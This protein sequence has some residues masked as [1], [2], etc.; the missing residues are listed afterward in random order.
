MNFKS[1]LFLP[2]LP[3]VFSCAQKVQ[4]SKSNSDQTRSAKFEPADGEVLIF[5]GQELDAVGGLANHSDGYY[6]FFPKPAGF[7]AYTDF[8]TGNNSFGYIHKGL[9][10]LTTT[11][12]WG[13]GPENVSLQVADPDFKNACLALGLDMSQGND[14]VTAIGGHDV[15][16]NRLGKYLKSLGNRPV[17]LRIGYEFDGVDWN[18]YKPVHYVPAFRRIHDKLQAM[19]VTNVAYTWQSKGGGATPKSLEEFYPGDEYV[20]WVAFSYFT[21]GEANHPMIQFG[22]DHHKPLLIAE[23]SP[24][25]PDEKFVSIPL[26]LTKTEDAQRAWKDWFAVFFETINKN[27]DVIKGF[28]YINS[29]WKTRP[30]WKNNGFFKN[31]DAR[32]TK[33]EY[34]K[35]QWLKETNQAKYIKAT[36]G[37]F[38]YLWKK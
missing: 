26:D 38:D 22:R 16:I 19:G 36:D 25:F 37:L 6:D 9:D 3:L 32:I 31:I 20:D 30:M 2:I 12:D 17:F 13:D 1:L 14:S 23:A 28:S 10:G 33:N 18:H 21:V 27:P 11:D 35:A 8:L 5:A 24:V 29:P 7:T 34:M 4:T 15:L